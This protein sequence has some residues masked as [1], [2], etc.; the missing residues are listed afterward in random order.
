MW[1]WA[2]DR[3]GDSGRDLVLYLGRPVCG[4][5]LKDLAEVAGLKDYR[6]VEEGPPGIRLDWCLLKGSG[7]EKKVHQ[8]AFVRLQP[9]QLN[10]W[11][12]SDVEPVDLGGI[13]QLAL[14]GCVFR[15]GRSDQGRPN[16]LQHL[17]LSTLD[18]RGV[19]EQTVCLLH[20]TFKFEAD[21][22]KHG[23]RAGL[24]RRTSVRIIPERGS[25][26]HGDIR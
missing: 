16:F 26:T 12:G 13:D 25:V 1:G 10:G 14:P 22:K 20:S 24:P 11:D 2:R 19:G 21:A 23:C 8:V 15:Y 3:H 5:K 18:D 6:S 17:A 9:I 4:S 7:A